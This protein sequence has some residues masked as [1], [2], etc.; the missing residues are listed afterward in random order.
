MR[1]FKGFSERDGSHY[2]DFEQQRS[3]RGLSRSMFQAQSDI[4]QGIQNRLFNMNSKNEPL[5]STDYDAANSVAM[6]SPYHED[7]RLMTS[8]INDSCKSSIQ[9]MSPEFLAMKQKQE[10]EQSRSTNNFIPGFDEELKY[11]QAK[12]RQWRLEASNNNLMEGGS[13]VTDYNLESNKYASL[14]DNG[15]TQTQ[16]QA[17]GGCFDAQ[18]QWQSVNTRNYFEN[19]KYSHLKH[20][21]P[22]DLCIIQGKPIPGNVRPIAGDPPEDDGDIFSHRLASQSTLNFC[23]PLASLK[24]LDKANQEKILSQPEKLWAGYDQSIWNSYSVV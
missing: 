16:A 1:D 19:N 6:R 8:G 17:Q 24:S 5:S 10:Q 13:A 3:C 15:Q 9:Q 22:E 11:K 23:D 14:I 4:N 12:E 2:L 21:S 18:G 7:N 20:L